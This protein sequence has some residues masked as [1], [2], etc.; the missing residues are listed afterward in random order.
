VGGV[1]VVAEVAG[2]LLRQEG[3]WRVVL[4]DTLDHFT[5]LV[6]VG[7]RRIDVSAVTWTTLSFHGPAVD[8][9][10]QDMMGGGSGMKFIVQDVGPYAAA[11]KAE[12]D[13][14]PVPAKDKF[15]DVAEQAQG[16]IVQAASLNRL[17][18]S[19]QLEIFALRYARLCGLYTELETEM[20]RLR[21]LLDLAATA[22][23][24]A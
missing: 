2:K 8:R 18:T 11:A 17:A 15:T 19:G 5:A 1:S 21:G 14:L 23:F 13:S 12:A 22:I 6:N 7:E 16:L 3:D 20:E 24:E 9:F 10:L 4:D